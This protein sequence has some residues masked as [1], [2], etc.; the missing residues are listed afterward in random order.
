MRDLASEELA[1]AC[2]ATSGLQAPSVTGDPTCVPLPLAQLVA[3]GPQRKNVMVP[4][5]VG[6]G[7]PPVAVPAMSARSVIGSVEP[8]W[9]VDCDGVV[10]TDA[11]HSPSTPRAKSNSVAVSDCEERVSPMN[12]LK[13]LPPM[14]AAVRFTPPSKNSETSFVE[15]PF[16]FAVSQGGSSVPF[17]GSLTVAHA[18][19]PPRVDLQSTPCATG[20][21]P[22]EP[23]APPFQRYTSIVLTTP[24]LV[25]AETISRSPST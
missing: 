2:P 7:P 18:A 25:N 13:H 11:P 10:V 24:P 20:V 5:G 23:V 4:V 1:Q 16:L 15:P 21:V 12:V 9:R 8:S 19:S 14:C 17:V 22:S 6:P 3:P